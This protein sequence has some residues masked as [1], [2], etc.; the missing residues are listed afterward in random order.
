MGAFMVDLR[1]Q[2]G[3]AAKALEFAILTAARSGEVRMAS[4]G[5][6]D[7]QTKTWSIP[8]SRMKAGVEHRVPLSEGAI[9][10]IR[11][12]PRIEG[13]DWVFP[14]AKNQSLSDMSLTAVLRRM[15]RNDITV[16]GMRSSFRD[17]ASESSA[18]SFGREAAEHAL[19]HSLPDRV[20]A[21]YRRGDLFERRIGLMQ[22]WADHCAAPTTASASV[23]P[24]RG[25][26]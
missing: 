12:M 11:Q 20:E 1:S 25:A 5:E 7:L 21:A 23:T 4:W 24:I 3:V 19:A 22:A 6:I 8:A 9:E 17:W 13:C 26:A 2:T 14:G 18:S 15:G 16:H 10:L